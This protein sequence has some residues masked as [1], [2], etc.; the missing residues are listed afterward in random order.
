MSGFIRWT[1]L[2]LASLAA[3]RAAPIPFPRPAAPPSSPRE[4][5]ADLA[6]GL[7]TGRDIS[8]KVAALR[9][10]YEDLGDL[11]VVFKPRWKGGIG[12]GPKGKGDGIE[13]KLLTLS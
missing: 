8:R 4:E 9:A 1:L 10:K 5:V 7:A 2:L 12:I 13:F 3:C 11:A 6:S